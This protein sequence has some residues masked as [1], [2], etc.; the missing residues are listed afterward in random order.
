MMT[1]DMPEAV[2]EE[3]R[4]PERIKEKCLERGRNKE[5][6]QKSKPRLIQTII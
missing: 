3:Q 4:Y 2:T 1:H 6:L 5:S